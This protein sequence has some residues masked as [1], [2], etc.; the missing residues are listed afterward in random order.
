ML[1]PGQVPAGERRNRGVALRL[2][3]RGRRPSGGA[4]PSA[5]RGDGRGARDA[6]G[7]PGDAGHADD[8]R[9]RQG[10]RRPAGARVRDGARPRARRR[11]RVEGVPGSR[12]GH[13][14]ADI[15][16]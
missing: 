8:H 2:R 3:R 4:L 9:R 7:G 5:R 11:E 1:L 6:A 15:A 10:R 14:A 12:P 16:R 13:A